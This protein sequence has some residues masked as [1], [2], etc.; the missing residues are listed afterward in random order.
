M[1]IIVKTGWPVYKDCITLSIVYHTRRKDVRLHPLHTRLYR[2]NCCPTHWTKILPSVTWRHNS[3]SVPLHNF[4]EFKF[5]TSKGLAHF[6]CWSGQHDCWNIG[7]NIL[8]NS[9]STV[10]SILSHLN[11]TLHRE[12][13]QRSLVQH[14]N[15]KSNNRKYHHAFYSLIYM[16]MNQSVNNN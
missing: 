4:C 12:Y 14:N 8:M 16:L 10:L 1:T 13:H 11:K 5:L 2:E 7:S 6:V 9:T 15:S 3:L